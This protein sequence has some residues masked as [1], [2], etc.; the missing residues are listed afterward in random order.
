MFPIVF[1]PLNVVII[2]T[3]AAKTIGTAM[4]PVKFAPPGKK[5]TRPN[6]LFKKIKRKL[7]AKMLDISD[8]VFLQLQ[9]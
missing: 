5:G 3:K 9:I 4:L 7:L 1:C 8:N 2:K 6:K